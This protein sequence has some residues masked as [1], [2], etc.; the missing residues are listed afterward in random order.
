M[1]NSA[2]G[3]LLLTPPLPTLRLAE[4]RAHPVALGPVTS[5]GP[6]LERHAMLTG[7]ALPLSEIPLDLIAPH[8]IGPR[9]HARDGK[10]EVQFLFCHVARILPFIQDGQ[11]R[12]ARWGNRRGESR[13]LPC[14]GWTWRSTVEAGSW[15]HCDAAE[16]VIP[17]T[18]GLDK[19]LWYRIV[20]GVRGLL[21][22]DEAGLLRVYPVVEPASRWYAVRTNSDWMPCVVVGGT[23]GE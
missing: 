8:N 17:A 6:Q 15:A 20:G 3:G 13:H 14:S 22:A 1:P 18:L 7:V 11:L 16:V 21:V 9:V 5:H 23:T 10:L 12:I 19:G 4:T 2:N